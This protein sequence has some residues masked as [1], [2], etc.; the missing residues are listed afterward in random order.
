MKA[1]DHYNLN[2]VNNLASKVEIKSKNKDVSMAVSDDSSVELGYSRDWHKPVNSLRLNDGQ[3]PNVNLQGK[4]RMK[5]FRKF[6]QSINLVLQ[7]KAN[8]ASPFKL[9]QTE[10]SVEQGL[11]NLFSLESLR[12]KEEILNYDE[13]E[14][15]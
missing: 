3:S 4:K 12:I 6:R 13:Q 7:P 8:Y 11:E 14:F 1:V 15:K 10:N 9:T 5:I 2:H